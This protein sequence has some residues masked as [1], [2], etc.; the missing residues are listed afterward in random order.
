MSESSDSELAA[1]KAELRDILLREGVE[2]TRRIRDAPREDPD[3]DKTRR[4]LHRWAGIAGTI[5]F[6]DIT[7]KAR[8]LEILLGQPWPE[9]RDPFHAGIER[10][11]ELFAQASGGG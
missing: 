5:G 9:I 2:Q 3:V 6:M 1:L 4:M 7:E 10:L 11:A 8:E